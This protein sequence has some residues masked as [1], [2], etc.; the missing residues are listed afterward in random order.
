MKKWW[1]VLI[2][3][4]TVCLVV[5]LHEAKLIAQ[6]GNDYAIIN[7]LVTLKERKHFFGTLTSERK[8]A[9]WREHFKT[10]LS[11]HPELTQAQKEV[12]NLAIV[13][14]SP[15]L[16]TRTLPTICG[17]D[18]IFETAVKN[19]FKE[20]PKL[21]DEIFG[22]PGQPLPKFAHANKSQDEALPTCECNVESACT[23]CG[24]NGCSPRYYSCNGSSW[25]CGC[26]WYS[27]C[28]T[29]CAQCV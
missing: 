27:A 14:V 23:S 22:Q 13:I 9:L 16:F 1:I 11:K 17:P 26:L 8:S 18:S 24:C 19:G 20:A 21:R 3:S 5:P 29:L 10:E 2:L 6:G 15:D 7:Q 28:N 4:V 12:V 25:G